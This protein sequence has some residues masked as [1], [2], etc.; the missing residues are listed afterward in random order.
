MNQEVYGGFDK[1]IGHSHHPTH[2]P[3]SHLE[4]RF[5][6]FLFQRQAKYEHH[7][8][9]VEF[10]IH[11]KHTFYRQEFPKDCKHTQQ[12]EGYYFPQNQFFRLFC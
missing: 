4:I 1:A 10:R 7:Q 5:R 2:M 11:K 12:N 6:P 9:F 8:L 3:A